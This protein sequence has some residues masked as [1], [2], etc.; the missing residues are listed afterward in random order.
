MK[1]PVKFVSQ[2][3]E[4]QSNELRAIIKT[5]DK[6]RVRQRA[7]ATNSVQKSFQLIKLPKFLIPIVIPFPLGLINGNNLVLVV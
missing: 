2:L 3:N 4:D 5:S 1:I 6:P 7:N